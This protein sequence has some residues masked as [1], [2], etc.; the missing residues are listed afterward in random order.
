MSQYGTSES[1]L[2]H[3]GGRNLAEENDKLWLPDAML[4]NILWQS[5]I[6]KLFSFALVW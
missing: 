3:D 1:A 5:K 2:P 4:K 6:Q